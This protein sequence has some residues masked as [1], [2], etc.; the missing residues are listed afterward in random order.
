MNN[1]H[2]P[3]NHPEHYTSHPSGVECIDVT[4]HMT[5]NIGNVI[6]YCW[7]SGL[8]GGN[9]SVQD[10]RKAA[11]YLNDEIRRIEG[12]P[13][14]I[15]NMAP[16]DGIKSILSVKYHNDIKSE[17]DEAAR[18]IHEA[19]NAVPSEAEALWNH[20]TGAPY[21]SCYYNNAPE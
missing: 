3:V 6:K 12:K 15:L 9:P 2:D 4:R 5:F 18:K 11:W 17:L 1:T 19:V 7:R 10:L 21:K 16:G 8:K 13:D 14:H 20:K